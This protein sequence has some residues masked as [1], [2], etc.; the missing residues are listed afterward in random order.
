[1]KFEEWHDFGIHNESPCRDMYEDWEAEREKF[2][3]ELSACKERVRELLGACQA[4]L[5]VMDKGDKPRKLDDALTWRENDERAHKLATVAI[6]K[7]EQ[8]LQAQKQTKE[9]EN[10]GM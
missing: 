2:I 6:A 7:A 10:G 1:M 3:A 8:A 9:V 4:L 5:V